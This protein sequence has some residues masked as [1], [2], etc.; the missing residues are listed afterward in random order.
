MSKPLS[1][2]SRNMVAALIN[3]F[4]KERDHGG[5]LLP[6]TAVREVLLF[7]Y[8]PSKFDFYLFLLQESG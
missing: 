6:L 5:A 1:S 8:S 3:Y 7:I 2:Q 4:E